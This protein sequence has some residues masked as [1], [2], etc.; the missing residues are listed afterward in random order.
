MPNVDLHC[1][2]HYSDGTLAPAELVRRAHANGVEVLALTDHDHLGGLDEAAEAARVCG[3]DLISG[4]EISVSWQDHTIHIVGLSIDPANTAL[5]AGLAQVRLGRD[6][7]AQRMADALAAV[8]LRDAL[9]GALKYCANPAL[10][11]RAHFARYIVEQG[12]ARDTRAVFEHYL[13][14]GKPGYV[15]HVWAELADAVGW[16]LGAGGVPVLAHPARYRLSQRELTTFLDDYKAAGGRGIEVCSGA[17]DDTD[18]RRF[19]RV[20]RQYGF[21]ASRASDFH[22]PGEGAVDLGRA[23]ALPPDLKPVWEHLSRS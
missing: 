8:G 3:I 14:P 16:I 15:S 4:V 23:P 2:S 5:Q 9:A 1:H 7:R 21:L 6:A 11:S 20:A 22:S 10:L 13:T 18:I 19:A 12:Y 17:H